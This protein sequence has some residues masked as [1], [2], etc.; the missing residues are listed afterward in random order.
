MTW[1]AQKTLQ[2][3]NWIKMTGLLSHSLIIRIFLGLM[4]EIP[5]VYLIYYVAFERLAFAVSDVVMTRFTMDSFLLFRRGVIGVFVKIFSD[6]LLI[7]TFLI[8]GRAPEMLGIFVALSAVL[9]GTG[10]SMTHRS[11]D[12]FYLKAVKSYLAS[13]GNISHYAHL[14]SLRTLNFKILALNF[15]MLGFTL[16]GCYFVFY[17][18]EPVLVLLIPILFN[19]CFLLFVNYDTEKFKGFSR[20]TEREFSEPPQSFTVWGTHLTLINSLSMLGIVPSCYLLVIT[21][22][23]TEAIQTQYNIWLVLVLFMLGYEFLGSWTVEALAKRLTGSHKASMTFFATLLLAISLFFTRFQIL[24]FDLLPT[25]L[26]YGMFMLYPFVM[27][28]CLKMIGHICM[29]QLNVHSSE[30]AIRRLQSVTLSTVPGNLLIAIYCVWL[31][32]TQKGLPSI[33]DALNS[34]LYIAMAIVFFVTLYWFLVRSPEKGS[35]NV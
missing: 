8:L 29:R 34:N 12:L 35:E 4:A 3:F 24:D 25:F 15:V 9:M 2:R 11:F 33:T 32:I 1:V 18:H 28:V 7:P 26:S 30:S 21:L 13:M 6:F 20:E 5:M 22:I 16:G 23:Q 10:Q 19:A 27:S 17:Y 14:P 31:A